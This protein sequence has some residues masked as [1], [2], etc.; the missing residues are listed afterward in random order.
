MVQAA[1]KA[2][3]TDWASRFDSAM[4]Q[5]KMDL[6]SMSIEDLENRIYGKVMKKKYADEDEDEPFV[7]PNMKTL[8]GADQAPSTPAPE[9]NAERRQNRAE[10]ADK[11]AVNAGR[12]RQGVP[13]GAGGGRSEQGKGRGVNDEG[14]KATGKPVSWAKQR[15]EALQS[16]PRA[17]S[18][19]DLSGASKRSGKSK[20]SKPP[21]QVVAV[22]LLQANKVPALRASLEDEDDAEERALDLF[23]AWKAKKTG[24]QDHSESS[25]EDG[26]EASEEDEEGRG[27]RE[28]REGEERRGGGGGVERVLS[29]GIQVVNTGASD[30]AGLEI[31]EGIMVVSRGG[32]VSTRPANVSLCCSRPC[33]AFLNLEFRLSLLF[34][35]SVPLSSV[36]MCGSD[37]Q[38]CI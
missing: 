1:K 24:F 5:K 15:A 20:P 11:V 12:G 29:G 27:G 34:L 37:S 28:G 38:P 6:S 7:V 31:D 19:A 22:E 2:G 14:Q 3:G 30:G 23:S 36:R 21:A 17:V 35:L 33:L 10:R 16:L 26:D 8:D 9:S 13:G 18:R 4:R 25:S 32:S